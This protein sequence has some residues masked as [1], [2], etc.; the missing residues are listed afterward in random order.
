MANSLIYETNHR[1]FW[2]EYKKLEGQSKQKPPH[3][4]HRT[5]PKDIAELFTDKY[6]TLYNSVPSDEEELYSIKKKIKEELL[7]YKDSEHI[8]TVY[9]VRKAI[10]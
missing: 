6:S 1:N 2:A 8:I 10:S 4:N 9:E 7:Q 3:M 5:E